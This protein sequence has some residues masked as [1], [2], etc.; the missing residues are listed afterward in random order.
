MDCRQ[1]RVPDFDEVTTASVAENAERGIGCERGEDVAD[2][3]VT[4][5]GSGVCSF[6]TD[7]VEDGFEITVAF[8]ELGGRGLEVG[9]S[10]LGF[11][12]EVAELQI[13]LGT[14]S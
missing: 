3:L 11:K 10:E 4:L 9:F 12:E 6:E 8:D 13:D 1:N 5:D 7:E 2:E 14:V